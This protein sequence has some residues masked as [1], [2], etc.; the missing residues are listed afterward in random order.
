[1]AHVGIHGRIGA[2]TTAATAYVAKSVLETHSWVRGGSA[3]GSNPGSIVMPSIVT[4]V[5]GTAHR[6]YHVLAYQF[7][8]EGGT[9]ARAPHSLVAQWSGRSSDERQV[10]RSIRTEAT[11]RHLAQQEAEHSSTGQDVSLSKRR[12]GF[13]S[14]MLHRGYGVAATL[15]RVRQPRRV[16]VPLATLGP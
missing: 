8:G 14:R 10:V 4:R 16:R 3:E 12:S 7:C 13:D 2:S 1:M 6:H 9:G 15:L 5:Q 11:M